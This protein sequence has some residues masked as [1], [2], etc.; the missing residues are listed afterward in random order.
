MCIDTKIILIPCVVTEILTKTRFS[1]MAALICILCGLPKGDR[2]ASSRF[3]KSTSRRYRNSK[4]K[5]LYE[6]YCTLIGPC[7]RT[8]RSIFPHV[9][10]SL[11][12]FLKEKGK[13]SLKEMTKVSNDYLEADRQEVIKMWKNKMTPCTTGSVNNTETTVLRDTG[14]TTC[15][16]SKQASNFIRQNNEKIQIY[17]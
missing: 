16:V 7:H 8:T 10:K 17:C 1:V 9:D 5:T 4:K 14:S 11:Q 3:L 2:A 12:I 13:L 15:V 6:A